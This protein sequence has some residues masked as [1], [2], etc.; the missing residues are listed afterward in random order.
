MSN[1]FII[2]IDGFEGDPQIIMSYTRQLAEKHN[3][4]AYD[5]ISE[6]LKSDYVFFLKTF[7]NTFPEVKLTSTKT[8]FRDVVKR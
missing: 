3:I 5:V 8:E 6:M 2:D 4:N 7:A 1:E